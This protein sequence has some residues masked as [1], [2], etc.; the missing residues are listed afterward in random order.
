M[1][2]PARARGG[3]KENSFSQ[4]HTKACPPQFARAGKETKKE[5][6]D[7]L[8][9][10]WGEKE[11]NSSVGHQKGRGGKTYRT[12]FIAKGKGTERR[13]KKESVPS[14]PSKRHRKN[15]A[16]CTPRKGGADESTSYP[17]RKRYGIP[18]SRCS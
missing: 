18:S 8:A 1:H 4:G 6:K 12:I 14:P 9:R 10:L 3:K 16:S 11:L 15:H 13:E 2:V 5:D 7:P 17:R